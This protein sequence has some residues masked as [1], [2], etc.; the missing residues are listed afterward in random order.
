VRP[1]CV[2][3]S[4]SNTLVVVWVELATGNVKA[5]TFSGANGLSVAGPATI[6][7]GAH[8]TDPYIDAVYYG[9]TNVTVVFR[10][11]GSQIRFLEVTPSTLATPTSAAVAVNCNTCLALMQDPDASGIRFVAT[12]DTAGTALRIVRVNSA[13][14]IQTNDAITEATAVEQ[15]AGVAYQAGAGW[16]VVYETAVALRACKKRSG[17][18]SALVS[19][20]GYTGGRYSLATGAWREPGADPMRYIIRY[21]GGEGGGGVAGAF[22]D[23]QRT[24]YE[25]ALEFENSSASITRSYLEAQAR[26]LPFEAS[27][28]LANA[29]LAHTQRT[30]PDVY[31][32]A[33]IRLLR[34][35]NAASVEA[36]QWAFD[37]WQ[38]TYLNASNVAAANIGEG[39][40]TG[41]TAYLPDGQ[42]LQ[43]ASGDIICGHG[44]STVPSISGLTA[45]AGGGLTASSAYQYIAT[46]DIWDD[47][48]NVWHGPPS[49][50]QIANLAAGQTKV[51]IDAW[52]GEHENGK[53]KR[54]V[55]FWRTMSNGSV[56]RLIYSVTNDCSSTIHTGFIDTISD[57][58]LAAGSEFLSAE[59]PTDLT[60]AFSHIALFGNR[61]WGA[62]RDFPQNVRWSKPLQAGLAP[63]FPPEFTVNV[64][65]ATGEPSAL[66]GIDDKVVLYKRGAI[67]I[68]TGTN[69]DNSGA[70]QFPEFI[71]IN[72]DVGS[73]N[74]HVVSTGTEVFFVSQ[75]GVHRLLR[76]LEVNWFQELDQFFNQPEI[77]GLEA[78]V[79]AVF[80]AQHNEI[81]LQTT[82][83]R[84][85]YNRQ[86]NVWMRDTGSMSGAVI[87]TMIGL[88]Q[89]IFR[90]NGQTWFEDNS[91]VVT[92]ADAGTPYTGIIRSPWIGPTE[93]WLRVYRARVVGLRIND[94]GGTV[95]PTMRI[96]FDNREDLS[97]LGTGSL[98][99]GAPQTF[100]G[101]VRPRRGKCSRFSLELTIPTDQ[102]VRLEAW[103]VTI[104]LKRGSQPLTQNDR[105]A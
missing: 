12:Y 82:N 71:R 10:T 45:A 23:P 27:A 94:G 80:S 88:V 36:D 8:A 34:F 68:S 5:Q 54:T 32:T 28:N 98:L 20:S 25:M 99:V 62:E 4:A 46:E 21:R 38:V 89:A 59:L 2:Y 11:A 90:P 24:Y 85:V 9:G 17:V 65:D 30:A 26:L 60:P 49:T 13:G 56:F 7:T 97:E 37:R 14:A 100:R 76:S 96:Y 74:A 1:R 29:S 84:F 47:A 31:E 57:A 83:Y 72:S 91:D 78:V 44:G 41:T 51:T 39:V 33:L 105:W 102:S 42:L 104:G 93:G 69:V 22:V 64:E 75:R 66:I 40:A 86:N 79:G 87:T 67:Y 50:A 16:E 18:V 58:T 77:G 6:G 92:V 103:A 73:I 70:G 19:I 35:D 81:R 52:F 55:K 48:G 63:E 101:E 61:L 53:R 95:A 3:N 15:V 43:S